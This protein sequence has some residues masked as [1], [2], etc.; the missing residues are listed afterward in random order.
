MIEIPEAVTLSRQMTDCFSGKAVDR[1]VA[2]G[3]PHKFACYYGDREAYS[4]I[5]AGRTFDGAAAVGGMVEGAVDDVRLLFSEGVRLRRLGPGEP[6]PA[7]RQLEVG[8]SDGSALIASVQMYGGLGVFLEGEN[9]NPYYL[10]AREKPSPLDRG[11]DEVYFDRLFANPEV[12]KLSAKAFLAT[13]QRI[14]GLGNGVLQDILYR[15]RIHPRRK[16]KTLR[17]P[18]RVHVFR[19]LK[20]TLREMTDLGGRDTE[21]DLYGNPGR[22]ATVMSR[23]NVGKPCPSCGDTIVKAAYMGGSVYFCPGCQPI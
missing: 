5:A 12:V 3:S 18:D 14:P 17:D 1:I 6:L 9:Q 8:F 21:S 13:E 19:A 23:S 15:A 7:K 2:G 10:V 20:E 16:I 4:T 11:F 22:F